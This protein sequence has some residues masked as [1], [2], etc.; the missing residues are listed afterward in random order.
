MNITIGKVLFIMINYTLL[1]RRIEETRKLRKISQAELAELT[2][3]SVSYICYIENA[4][5]KAS[6]QSLVLIAGVMGT[7]LDSLLGGNQSNGKGEYHNELLLLM[8]DC[9]HYE[10]RIIFEQVLSLKAA[11]RD[12]QDLILPP[13]LPSGF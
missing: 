4:K 9:T 10:K 2:E 6:L 3:L 12:N 13:D 11:L 1:G 8:E 7:T 5:R